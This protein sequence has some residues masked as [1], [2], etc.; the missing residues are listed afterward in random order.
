MNNIRHQRE[1]RSYNPNPQWPGGFFEVLEEVGVPAKHRP[2]YAQRVRQFFNVQL[3]GRRRRDMRQADVDAFLDMLKASP[4]VQD[5]QVDQAEEALLMYYEQFRGIPLDAEP[6]GAPANPRSP[7]NGHPDGLAMI[8]PPRTVKPLLRIPPP[9]HRPRPGGEVNWDELEKAVTQCLRVQHYALK[10]EKSYLGWIRR[11]VFFHHRRKPSQMGEHEI[12]H[13]LSDL[14]VN[15]NVAPSTQNQALN[16]VVF[17]YKKVLKLDVG[18]FADF[19]RA[20]KRERLPVVLSRAEVQD[21]M[22]QMEGR[23]G[24]VARLL[25]GTG[26]RV[27]EGLRLRVQD[28]DMDRNEITVRSG[29]G[30]KDRRVPLPGALKPELRTL[31]EDRHFLFEEDKKAK[32]H[33]VELPHA[34][35]RKYPN[36]AYEWPW[37]YVFPAPGY[38]TDPRSGAVRR[39]HLHEVNIQR[40]VRQ[41]ARKADI[42]K[43][44]TPHVLRHSFATHLLEAG[45]DIRTVQELLGH[46]DV[47]TTMIYTHVLNKGPL[48]VVSPLDTL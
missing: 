19:A 21:L 40:A 31:L 29:K 33:E 2:F 16:A 24:V 9:D 26:M 7:V 6:T 13:F 43:R 23:E 11:F 41:A 15:R 38:S 4:R 44:V 36:A 18:D 45:Q 39:H 3:K 47:K 20:R 8:S 27:A 25:Y 46:S 12:H 1:V 5:W 28:V 32:M 22:A 14:A 37:Q 48:G 30:D 35:A 34:L 17:L 42:Q 10:T